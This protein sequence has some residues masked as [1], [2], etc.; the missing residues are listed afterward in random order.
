MTSQD[1]NDYQNIFLE[2]RPLM[3][4]RAPIEFEKGAFPNSQNIPILDDLQ[5]W[6]RYYR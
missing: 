5:S 1:T 4:V 6:Y 2:D 3:D